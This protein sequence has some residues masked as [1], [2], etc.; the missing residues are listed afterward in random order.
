MVIHSC[1]AREKPV[2]YEAIARVEK[3]MKEKEEAEAA[4]AEEAA[5]PT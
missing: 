5:T 2:D 3:E 4:S 1:G